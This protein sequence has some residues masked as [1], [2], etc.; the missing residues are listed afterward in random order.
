MIAGDEEKEMLKVYDE[1][2]Y[3]SIAVRLSNTEIGDLEK[4]RTD[5]LA[6]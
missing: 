1:W 5:F 4:N 6:K 3:R 2:N